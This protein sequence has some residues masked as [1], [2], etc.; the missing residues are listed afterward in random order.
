MRDGTEALR[1]STA[2]NPNECPVVRFTFDVIPWHLLTL[3]ADGVR[4]TLSTRDDLAPKVFAQD[5]RIERSSARS[6]RQRRRTSTKSE[7]AHDF[8]QRQRVDSFDRRK[9]YRGNDAAHLLSISR[10]ALYKMESTGSLKMIRVGGRTLVSHDEI[11]R[12]L[13][14]GD[15]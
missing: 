8:Q 11:E 14:A 1:K 10:S 6:P 15:H 7:A 12:L 3:V 2:P 4:P 9:A 13:S 5:E